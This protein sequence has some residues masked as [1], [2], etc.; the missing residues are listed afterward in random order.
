MKNINAVVLRL[1]A[2]I[3]ISLSATLLAFGQLTIINT[4]STDTLQTKSFYIELDALGKPASYKNGGFQS[5]G[6]RTVYGVNRKLE[7]GVSFFYTR[8]DGYSPLEMQFSAKRKLFS[9]E[10]FGIAAAIGAT[11]YVPLNHSAGNRTFFVTYANFS[12][13]IH[14][15]NGLRITAGAY[16]IFNASHTFGARTG[17]T[18]ALEQPLTKRLNFVADWSSGRN[19]FGYLAT[20]L[21]LIITKNQS[22]T[23]A[24]NF[25][26]TGRGNNYLYGFYAVTF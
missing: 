11:A 20:G 15:A 12:K 2:L 22:A 23:V 14:H 26:N 21:N 24:Y 13:V 19:R 4:P 9:S 5:Y 3:L 18:L 17:A 10:R 8:L 1:F 16:Q 6:Y 25:G 7:V